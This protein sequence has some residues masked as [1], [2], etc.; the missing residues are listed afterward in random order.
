MKKIYV[1]LVGGQ[2]APVF[3][4]L[5]Y[6]QSSE[7]IL[8]CSN[9]TKSEAARIQHETELPTTIYEI[10]ATDLSDIDSCVSTI[11]EKTV[12]CSLVV[13]VS[14]GLKIWSV[15]FYE[16]FKDN[17]DT[18]VIYLD[19]NNVVWNLVTR[20]SHLMTF[21]DWDV[22]FRLQGTPLKRYVKL[23]DF[24]ETDDSALKEIEKIRAINFPDF[25]KLTTVLKAEWVKI[26]RQEK[27]G[28][29]ELENGSFV[30]WSKENQEATIGLYNKNKGNLIYTE[31]SSPNLLSLLFN[32]GWFEYKIA[33]LLSSWDKAEEIWLNCMFLS[34]KNDV[35][36]EVDIIVN[37]GSKLLFV[38]CKTQISKGT[39]IDKF[40]SVVKN[41]G[42][43]GSKSI[44]I[45][46]AKLRPAVVEK[47]NDNN[48][49]TF[50]LQDC[51]GEF[52]STQERLA[53]RL[54]NEL[55]NINKR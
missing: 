40:Q 7:I 22:L 18:Q 30:A 16:A 26:L 11:K 20:E 55:F 2:P 46:D 13:N 42:G 28:K 45:T 12:G 9:R 34:T 52:S 31:L 54:D 29:F 33:R 24:T 5:E 14:G 10:S 6:S 37:A 15:L 35:K 27:V 21:K 23:S 19:Q 4:G 51:E 1:A 36:N 39:D 53:E 25:N 48:M 32:A 3:F 44:F 38:E 50:S 43:M 8:I 47:C 41:Y 17:L 49:L